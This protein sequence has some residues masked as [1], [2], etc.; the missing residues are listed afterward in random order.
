MPGLGWQDVFESITLIHKKFNINTQGFSWRDAF[1]SSRHV[2]HVMPMMHDSSS[3]GIMHLRAPNGGVFFF[4]FFFF[5]FF[6]FFFS[7]AIFYFLIY[8]FFFFFF[9]FFVNRER[10]FI[11]I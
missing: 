11:I 6:F 5:I 9:F 4:F 10:T 8:F 1:E 7:G 3:G 2:M